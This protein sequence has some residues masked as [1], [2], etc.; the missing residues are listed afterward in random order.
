[1]LFELYMH[2]P[3]RGQI[4]ALAILVSLLIDRLFG[5]P[6][7]L[8]HPV[9]WMGCYLQHCG[10]FVAPR[11]GEDKQRPAFHFL[12]GGLALIVPI[13]LLAWMAWYGQQLIETLAWYW[14]GMVLGCALKPLLSWRML[15][16]EVEAVETALQSSL[17]AGRDQLARLV[18]REVRALDAH[19]VR[20]S[21][22]ETLAENLND[23]V[24]AAL[25]WFVLFGLPGALIYRFANTAD[26]MWGYR[27]ARHGR[28]WTWA[29][30]C[31]AHLDDVLSWP[32]ARLTA[33][34]MYGMAWRYPTLRLFHEA[35]NTSS[36]NG[37][38]PM[39]AMALL[40]DVCLTKPGGY[41][42][43]AAGKPADS[44]HVYS[45]LQLCQRVVCLVSVL[46]VSVLLLG[47]IFE[48]SLSF[49]VR[50]A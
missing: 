4:L 13:L 19:Q 17:Q 11:A 10:Q 7:E 14:Q 16:R 47:L 43:H 23:S 27:G 35:K 31:A 40:L 44:V 39:G 1:M 2:L 49:G 18:S 37:G 12:A 6:P 21:A 20:E 42:L 29:G 41:V 8:S 9:V 28:I 38:W 48:P 22:I 26:A 36:P 33:L 5:E 46:S 15:Y 50:H 45:A 32:G 3:E 30:K 34:I 24:I 25:F